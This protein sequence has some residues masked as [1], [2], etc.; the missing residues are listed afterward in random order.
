MNPK[1]AEQYRRSQRALYAAMEQIC[2]ALDINL[3]DAEAE[4]WRPV[5]EAIK[6]WHKSDLVNGYLPPN[7]LRRAFVKGAKWWE[8]V[9]TDATMWQSD[10]QRAE[11]EAEKRYPGGQPPDE[12]AASDAESGDAP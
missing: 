5:V 10:Q 8:W 4:D 6:A 3:R 1:L 7:D 9:S 2:Q 12:A 11:E